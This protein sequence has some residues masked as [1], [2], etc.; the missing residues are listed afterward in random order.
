MVYRCQN[1][2]SG[3]VH[4][5]KIIDRRMIQQAHNVLLEQFQV[6]IQVLQ[7]M[8]HPNIIHIDDVYLTEAKICMVSRC[9][10]SCVRE[11]IRHR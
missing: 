1:R 10:V 8:D 3:N 4:A 6:E 5:C 7:S 9:V 2:R 11:E